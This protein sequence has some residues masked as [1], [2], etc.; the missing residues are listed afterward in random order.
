[1][2]KITFFVPLKS[3]RV[4]GLPPG[5]TLRVLIA[6]ATD[7]D[8]DRWPAGTEYQLIASGS[9]YESPTGRYSEVV[10]PNGR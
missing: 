9:H 5:S 7:A 3:R 2:T 1:M 10:I 6:S 4:R 8:G